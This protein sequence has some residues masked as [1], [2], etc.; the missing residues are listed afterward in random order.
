MIGA[1]GLLAVATMYADY[2]WT[3]TARVAARDI[4]SKYNKFGGV[5]FQGH[6]GFQFYMERSGANP[7]DFSRD[8]IRPGDFMI[9]PINNTN[10]AQ[11]DYR[12][13]LVEV[14]EF[15]NNSFVATMNP[16]YKA[17][18]YASIWGATPYGVKKPD[19]ER[20]LVYRK[21]K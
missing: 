16:D 9:I 19:K 15:S 14:M 7:V 21:I 10:L 4:T 11:P 12:F 3:N 8:N 13:D 17:G 20:Y 2:A 18:F 6:W 5:W 1:A